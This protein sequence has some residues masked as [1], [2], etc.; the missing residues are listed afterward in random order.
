MKNTI[1]NIATKLIL[2]DFILILTALY[3]YTTTSNVKALFLAIIFVGALVL[4][5]TAIVMEE[6]YQKCFIENDLTVIM[7]VLSVTVSISTILYIV[8]AMTGTFSY[9][10]F[11]LILLFI[12]LVRK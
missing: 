12:L 7:L 6:K 11:L 3:V 5:K 1:T 9:V 10:V 2:I 4:A 8:A